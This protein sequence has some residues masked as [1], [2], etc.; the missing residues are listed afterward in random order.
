MRCTNRESM[1]YKYERFQYADGKCN[2][3]ED[4][5][6]FFDSEEDGEQKEDEP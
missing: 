3:W 1:L 5:S 6:E 4:G 2:L